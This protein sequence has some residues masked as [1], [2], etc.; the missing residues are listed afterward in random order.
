MLQANLKELDWA[1]PKTEKKQKKNAQPIAKDLDDDSAGWLDDNSMEPDV[2]E[3]DLGLPEEE[4][5][6][7]EKAERK[8]IKKELKKLEK[9]AKK[10][11][12][13]KELSDKNAS[14]DELQ[15]E[16]QL[17]SKKRR[18]RKMAEID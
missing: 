2:V 12:H 5:D 4:P 3:P 10:K 17:Q 18:M 11:H 6:V 15:N 9:K 13:H 8:R 1:N 7:D 14:G 16:D